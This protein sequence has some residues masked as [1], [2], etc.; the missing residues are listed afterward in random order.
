MGNIPWIKF[1]SDIEFSNSSWSGPKKLGEY[2]IE[3]DFDWGPKAWYSYAYYNEFLIP[4][5]EVKAQNV[6]ILKIWKNDL[7]HTKVGYKAEAQYLPEIITYNKNTLG[8]DIK[9]DMGKTISLTKLVVNHSKTNCQ[10]GL[11]GYVA[12]SDDG[13]IWRKEVDPITYPQVPPGVLG[14]TIGWSDVN[15][16]YL[17]AGKKARYIILDPETESSCFLKDS[18][19]KVSGFKQNP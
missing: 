6:P 11:L 16:V 8:T 18:K 3:L 15:F 2:Q 19:I 13:K 14:N 10:R 7:E 4:V 12:L 1:R 17:F 5:Y 9:I